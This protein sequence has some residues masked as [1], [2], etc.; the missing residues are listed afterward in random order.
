VRGN[1]ALIRRGTLTFREKARYAKEAGATAVVVSEYPG[2][3]LSIFNIIP[4]GCPD[5]PQCPDEW[6]NYEFPITLGI[7]AENGDKL[8]QRLNTTAT[9][10]Y[11]FAEYGRQSGTSMAAPHV[12][13]AAAI[14][15]SLKPTLKSV[16]IAF[17][18]KQTARDTADE[19]WDYETGYGVIDALAAAKW[20]AP[21]KFNVPPPD[22]QP[23]RRR[24]VRP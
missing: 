16:D 21:E 24:G 12:S 20:V 3:K 23:G 14:L 19:G 8:R 18:L 11:L 9:A 22:Y 17:I 10:S 13:S 5:G 7:S 6:K 2:E 1:I 4:Q 15:L